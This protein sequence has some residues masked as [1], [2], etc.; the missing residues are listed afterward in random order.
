MNILLKYKWNPSKNPCILPAIYS[1]VLKPVNHHFYNFDSISLASLSSRF[2]NQIFHTKFVWL[3]HPFHSIVKLCLSYSFILTLQSFF[4][5]KSEVHLIFVF[6]FVG[7]Q[8]ESDSLFRVG[9]ISMQNVSNYF[10]ICNLFFISKFQKK[11]ETLSL[12]MTLT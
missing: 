9:L 11:T 4:L 5:L 8:K 6:K 7:F 2:T 10:E 12:S 3:F 1:K